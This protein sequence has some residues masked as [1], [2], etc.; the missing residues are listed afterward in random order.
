MVRRLGQFLG[1]SD[2]LRDTPLRDFD[3]LIGLATARH[4]VS[5]YLGS[6]AT[7]AISPNRLREISDPI[8]QLLHQ[9]H[10]IIYISQVSYPY[11]HNHNTDQYSGII[12]E[13]KI[14]PSRAE[15]SIIG[16]VT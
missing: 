7:L 9:L 12:H 2:S 16:P 5:I 13:P 14:N 11:N 4:I 1:W 6:T 8:I 10:K 3:F 15:T